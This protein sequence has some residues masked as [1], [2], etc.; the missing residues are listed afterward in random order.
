[1][2]RSPVE[3]NAASGFGVGARPALNL[4]DFSSFCSFFFLLVLPLL[5][6]LLGTRDGSEGDIA[7]R[8]VS[9][10]PGSQRPSIVLF[11][12]A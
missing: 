1:M 9:L 3:M 5:F 2:S 12:F 7:H 11:V 10:K 6:L 8:R 4:R